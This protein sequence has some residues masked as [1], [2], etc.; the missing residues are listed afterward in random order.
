MRSDTSRHESLIFGDQDLQSLRLQ[1]LAPSLHVTPHD[2]PTEAG[3]VCHSVIRATRHI[4][5]LQ[6]DAS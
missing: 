4:D 3:D 1:S 5:Q 6:D 2:D